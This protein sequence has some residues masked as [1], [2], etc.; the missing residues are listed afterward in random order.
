MTSPVPLSIAAALFGDLDLG[1][2]R[3]DRRFRDVVGAIAE[4]PGASLP[5][6]FP[7]PS[8]YHACLRLFDGPRATHDNI[9]SAHQEAVLNGMD[10][11]TETLLLIHDATLLDFSGHTSLKDE[12]GPIGNGG[13]RGWIAQQILA[14]DPADRTVLGLVGQLLHVRV[15][16]PKGET[17][18]QRRDR[19]GRESR[20]WTRGLDE[21]GPTPPGCHRID[22]ADRGA[23]TFEF[24]Q[25]L[26]G[27]GRH[28]VVRSKHNRALGTGSSEEK[29]LGLPHD[30]LRTRPATA[31][32]EMDIP[33]RAGEKGRTARLSGVSEQVVLRPP[34]VKK[35][36]YRSEPMEVAVVRVWEENPPA[37]QKALEWFLIANEPAGTPSEIQQLAAW[38]ACRMQIEEFHKVQKSGMAVEGC[39]VQ[40]VEKMAAIV[41][42]LSVLAVPLMNA[43]LAMR[44]PE[45][46]AL[47]ATAMVPELWVEVLKRRTKGRPREWTVAAFWNALARLGG[48]LKNPA[49]HPPGWITLWRGWSILHQLI[50]Y[51][52]ALVGNAKTDREPKAEPPP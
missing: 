22:L 17:A 24:L 35:G 6:I 29:A 34:H 19:C 5:Q 41:A 25:E 49:K 18:A 1:D 32:W 26:P 27:R 48:Y 36:E 46:A 40:S 42:V 30:Q 15:S 39:Q 43:R 16:P 21:I 44:D 12:L 2:V 37:G 31:N 52:V 10:R 47:P 9:L 51:H 23:D 8:Q 11:R 38:H 20:L 33:D 45:L 14:V 28:F 3:R 4:H 7:D 50:R 13:G